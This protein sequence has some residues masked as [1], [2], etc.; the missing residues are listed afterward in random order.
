MANLETLQDISKRE[1]HK[2]LSA[3]GGK[4]KKGYVH[5]STILKKYLSDEIEVLDPITKRTVKKQIG[6]VINLKLIA[7][8]VKGDQKAIKMIFER[9]EG[10]PAQ[11]LNLGGQDGNPLGVNIKVV[12]NGSDS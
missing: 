2:S 11:N 6:E 12:K 5:L 9:M 8:A 7:A 3:K 10:M 1:D 4:N